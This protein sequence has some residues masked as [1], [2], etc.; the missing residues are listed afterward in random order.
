M[1]GA[2]GG[3]GSTGLG[4]QDLKDGALW[5]RGAKANH[6]NRG[7]GDSRAKGSWEQR[8]VTH[9]GLEQVPGESLFARVRRLLTHILPLESEEGMWDILARRCPK[10]DPLADFL[11]TEE[12]RDLM[13]DKD[14]LEHGE[15]ADETAEK[16]ERNNY[17]EEYRRAKPRAPQAARVKSAA[18]DKGPRKK[19]TAISPTI[20]EAEAQAMMPP[21]ARLW[22]D[23]WNQRWQLAYKGTRIASRSFGL[24][25][26]TEAAKLV[27]RAAWDYH[28]LHGGEPPKTRSCETSRVGAQMALPRP[29]QP[30]APEGARAPR[31]EPLEK[32]RIAERVLHVIDALFPLLHIPSHT[33]SLLP[34]P[35]APLDIK[36]SA[37]AAPL[38]RRLVGL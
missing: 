25:G 9:M 19:P 6:G 1:S 20:T 18:K 15:P 14:L 29:S 4:K 33:L 31:R 36:P 35:S 21:G 8:K 32:V 30:L 22:K 16:T 5:V 13:E 37:A 7:K 23:E 34:S 2:G 26:Y 28:T 11:D 17:R 27:A 12:A 10:P 3:G 24:Y 38:R